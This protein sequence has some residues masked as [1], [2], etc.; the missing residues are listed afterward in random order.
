M[1]RKRRNEKEIPTI[2][3]EVEKTKLTIRYLCLEKRTQCK[4]SEQLFPNRQP[5]SYPNLHKNVKTYIIRFK[6][7]KNRLQKLKQM[8]PQQKYHLG[9]ISNTTYKITGGAY[10]DFTGA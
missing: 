4:P 1:I 2:K 8:E 9:T 7:H 10:I 6:Q 5:I 3:T